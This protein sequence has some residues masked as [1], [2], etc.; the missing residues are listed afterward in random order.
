MSKIQTPYR[1]DFVGSF[2]RPQALKDAKA[3]FQAGKITKEEF[4]KV[5]NEEITKVVAKQK[6]LGYH[7]ITDGEFRRTFWHLDFMWGFEG[8]AHENTGGG[9][10]FNGELALLDD[11]YLVGKIKAKAHPFVEYFKFLKQFEDENTVAKYT[12]PA[13]AQTFQQMI[14]P[15]NYETTR[16]FYPTN[17]ELIQ[18]IG[19][20]YQDVIKQFYEAGCRNLQFDDCTWGAIVGDAAKQRYASLG[21]DLEDVK[22]Q[23]LE[24][25]NLA[26]ENKPADMVITSHICRGNYHSTFFTSGPYDSVADY[27]FA[28]ENVDALFLEYDDARSGGFAPLA[29]VSPDKKVVL[30]LI[31]TKTPQLENKETI[32]KRIKDASK[33]IPL[34][35]LYL[36]PQCGFASCE[37]GNKLTEDEQ[38]AKLKLVKEI[39][40]EVWGK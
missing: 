7:V 24:V 30:G 37:I 39:A 40:E 10:S 9:V 29:K 38:W 6:K 21:I 25:N 20:A 26:L 15:A 1:Y 23:L 19:V 34:D 11:T 12:I 13:P 2:L 18:D 32:I 22:K 27:V 14:V 4:D 8:V 5:V 35:R 31:T 3:A 16:K 36:S 17:E 33:Y 28:K